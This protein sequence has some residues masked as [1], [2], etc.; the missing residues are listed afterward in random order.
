MVKVTQEESIFDANSINA[1]T[2]SHTSNKQRENA[3]AIFTSKKLDKLD[4]LEDV[5]K[6]L[7][8][9]EAKYYESDTETASDAQGDPTHDSKTVTH[10]SNGNEKV[11]DTRNGSFI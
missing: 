5:L 6:N 1:N 2:F 3:N 11:T 4:E 8:I 10:T 9:N 7:T